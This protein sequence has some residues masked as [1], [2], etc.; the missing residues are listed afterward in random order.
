MIFLSLPSL[1]IQGGGS[2]YHKTP[3][4]LQNFDGVFIF[5]N[6]CIFLFK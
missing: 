3:L 6:T 2:D 4:L 1:I 5:Y